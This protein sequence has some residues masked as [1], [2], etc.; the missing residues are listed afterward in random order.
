MTRPMI[1]VVAPVFN[2]SDTIIEYMHRT[3][4]TLQALNVPFEVLLVD[5]G[6]T[7]GSLIAMKRSLERYPGSKIVMLDKNYGQSNAIAAGLSQA[8]GEFCVVMDSDLQDKP[9]DIPT[10]Y[11]NI[12]ESDLDMVIASRSQSNSSAKRNLLSIAFYLAANRLT[13]IKNPP[14]AGVFRIIR[15]RCM[16]PIFSM[17]RQPGTLL[18]QLHARGCSWKT[19]H[20]ERENRV[21]HQSSYTLCKLLTLAFTR[22]LVFGKIPAGQMGNIG[23]LKA[24]FFYG[25]GVKRNSFCLKLFAGFILIVSL[26]M[27]DKNFL[28]RFKPKFKIQSVITENT[29]NGE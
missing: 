5:D 21:E 9:E 15:S 2:G 6:S 20:L 17:P 16:K 27:R 13:T 4:D 23:I 14:C 3:W 10:L 29:C 11:Q 12:L 28:Y 7:D 25:A 26:L 22:I 1:S 8:R 18:S 24:L 19:V